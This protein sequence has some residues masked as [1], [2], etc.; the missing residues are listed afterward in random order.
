MATV[1]LMFMVA[2]CTAAVISDTTPS[3]TELYRLYLAQV[4][5]DANHPPQV[6]KP[7][8]RSTFNDALKAGRQTNFF[9]YFFRCVMNYKT[10]ANEG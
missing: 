1:K 9:F 4:G 6:N 8:P 3:P 2:V 7:V 10:T 5:G